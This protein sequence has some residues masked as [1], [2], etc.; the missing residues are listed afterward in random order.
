MKK[1]QIWTSQ[2]KQGLKSA[3]T[4]LIDDQTRYNSFPPCLVL[5]TLVENEI[6]CIIQVFYL[7]EN[8]S[9][10]S[11]RWHLWGSLERR[12]LCPNPATV[13]SYWSKTTY[14]P[15]SPWRINVK[16]QNKI[17]DGTNNCKMRQSKT[18]TYNI[19]SFYNIWICISKNSNQLNHKNGCINNFH[20]DKS[21]RMHIIKQQPVI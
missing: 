1:V 11:I 16:F 15:I 13:E 12:V 7:I 19:T 18:K 8:V 2:T 10:I 3:D 21:Q 20:W 17:I 4:L 5:T 14:Y 9:D 6:T